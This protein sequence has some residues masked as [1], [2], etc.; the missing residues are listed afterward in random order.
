M[1]FHTPDL[2]Y[3]TPMES[4]E[5]RNFLVY[6]SEENRQ[7]SGFFECAGQIL[8]L[9]EWYKPNIYPVYTP[10]TPDFPGSRIP[11]QGGYNLYRCAATG[12]R[13][14][15]PSKYVELVIKDPKDTLDVLQFHWDEPVI[16]YDQYRATED[17]EEEVFFDQQFWTDKKDEKVHL[18]GVSRYCERLSVPAEMD[19]WPVHT[20]YLRRSEQMQ[21]LRELV[22]EDG[23]E[24]LYIDFDLPRLTTIAIPDSVELIVPPN[25]IRNTQWFRD[26][27]DGP[28]YFHNY[29]CGTKGET[30]QKLELKAGT[31]G[32]VQDADRDVPWKHIALPE[33][34]RYLGKDAFE[35][36]LQ[37]EQVDAPGKV[38]PLRNAFLHFPKLSH[39]FTDD[40]PLEKSCYDE[41]PVIRTG[42]DLYNLGRFSPAAQA[43]VMRGL[44]PLPPRLL[45]EDGLMAEF[46]YCTENAK[47]VGCRILFRLPEGVPAEIETWQIPRLNQGTWT[48]AFTPAFFH[49]GADYLESCIWLMERGVLWSADLEDLE[50]E[51]YGCIPD[52]FKLWLGRLPRPKKERTDPIHPKGPLPPERKVL[53][54]WSWNRV[55]E[56]LLAR[57]GVTEEE[58]LEGG[59]HETV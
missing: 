43:V 33:S 51:W 21:N 13:W 19:G 56:V 12:F 53:F 52:A 9:D 29:Y 20:V 30:G 7:A 11:I 57:Y 10:G 26:Q 36:N 47:E 41:R 1:A 35:G 34:C 46:W 27:P 45:D 50:E 32:V 23:V 59:H 15:R 14:V 40:P 58:I 25:G 4:R 6:T 24:K 2:P 39:C 18:C 31:A 28:V 8:Y 3:D 38:A 44:E 5:L 49:L 48:Q 42:E 55:K 17:P 54:G 22:V 37:L 16:T